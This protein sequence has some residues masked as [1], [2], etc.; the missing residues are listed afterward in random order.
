MFLNLAF[1]SSELMAGGA[2]WVQTAEHETTNKDV[3]AELCAPIDRRGLFRLGGCTLIGFA[4]ALGVG[5][6]SEA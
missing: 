2:P 6:H 5:R 1:H 3:L 4:K